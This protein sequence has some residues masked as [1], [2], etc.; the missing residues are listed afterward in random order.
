MWYLWAC[1]LLG[2]IAVGRFVGGLIVF[3]RAG[4]SERPQGAAI[5]LV[6]KQ[7][8]ILVALLFT[9]PLFATFYDNV[10]FHN[11]GIKPGDDGRM[12]VWLG[13]LGSVIVLAIA[14]WRA[15]QAWKT[16]PG[17][18]ATLTI[19]VA[20]LAGGVG[21]VATTKQ[22]VFASEQVG[23]L[24]FDDIRD[25]VKDMNCDSDVLIVQWQ[26]QQQGPTRYRCPDAIVLNQW[27]SAPFVPW[28]NYTE[29]S[30]ADLTAALHSM[31]RNA[32]KPN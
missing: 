19:V 7:A 2:L 5:G 3:V 24:S 26:Q 29:G 21:L 27:T 31:W 20:L 9:A 6:G 14:A 15:Y 10:A 8:E 11:G 16:K 4:E 17:L 23:W 32:I 12:S 13:L 30:S 18:N 28:P 1:L 22:L 25:E